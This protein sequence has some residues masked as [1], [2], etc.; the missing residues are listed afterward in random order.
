M[1]DD[2]VNLIQDR[3]RSIAAAH[4]YP[5]ARI[6]LFPTLIIVA[7]R[8]SEPAVIRTIDSVRQLRLDQASEVIAIAR[9]AERAEL[10]RRWRW[11]SCG[12]PSTRARGLGRSRT[13]RRTAC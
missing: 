9:S 10:R 6:R 4:G 11:R 13:S 5:H 3:L 8:D 1:S 2:A 7:L 12:K